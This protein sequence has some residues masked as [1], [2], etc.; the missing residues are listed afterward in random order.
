MDLSFVK[1]GNCPVQVLP[2]SVPGAQPGNLRA[3]EVLDGGQ[4]SAASYLDELQIIPEHDH[5]HSELQGVSHA[6]AAPLP[7]SHGIRGFSSRPTQAQPMA[8]AGRAGSAPAR[9]QEG[10]HAD[11]LQGL[12]L[13]RFAPAGRLSGL[14]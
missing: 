12:Q 6:P 2:D 10:G 8:A 7:P 11:I 9:I 3:G 14:Q 5:L 1:P 4:P 13:E